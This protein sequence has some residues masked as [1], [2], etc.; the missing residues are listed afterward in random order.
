MRAAERSPDDARASNHAVSLCHVLAMRHARSRCGPA[1]RCCGPLRRDA[2]RPF[3]KV[4][5]ARWRAFGRCHQG[6]L[7]IKRGDIA[8]GLQL[9]RSGLTNSA[10][11]DACL[12]G[13]LLSRV[14]W[15][16]PWP[17]RA[18]RRGTCRSSRRRSSEP[19]GPKSAG[20]SP[21]CC[22]SRASC[23]CCRGAP[24]AAAAAEDHFRQ[25]LD[26]ARRQ[27]ALSWELRAATSLARLLRDQGRPP[28]RG[29]AAAGLRSV[30]RGVR[31]RRPQ[32]GKGASR[33]PPIV[34]S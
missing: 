3:D 34:R 22:A 32:G 14:R 19:S 10:R 6:V 24:G 21:S 29:A 16:K 27:G 33:R 15:R 2:D 30:H 7:V 25:A 8:T 9:L 12:F 17:R 26:W 18:D 31:H 4:F 5:A 1:T 23:C 13:I 11:V 20:A 28:M